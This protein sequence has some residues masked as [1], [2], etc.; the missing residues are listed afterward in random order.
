MIDSDPI[1]LKSTKKI[2]NA[3]VFKGIDDQMFI[4]YDRNNNIIETRKV[5]SIF[6]EEIKRT[7]FS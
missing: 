6:K 3:R 2:K 1:T 5:K 4:I 7:D